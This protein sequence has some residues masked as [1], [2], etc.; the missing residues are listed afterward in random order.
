MLIGLYNNIFVLD[1]LR[2]SINKLGPSLGI[3]YRLSI[4][5]DLG[6]EMYRP[7]T[8]VTIYNNLGGVSSP[9]IKSSNVLGDFPL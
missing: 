8:F 5:I 4:D 9:H 6:F 3:T 1:I 2:T 7:T